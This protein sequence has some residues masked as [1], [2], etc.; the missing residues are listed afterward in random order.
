SADGRRMMFS[1]PLT[2]APSAE[3]WA[4]LG[5]QMRKLDPDRFKLEFRR[6]SPEDF[7]TFQPSDA[8][9]VRVF[10]LQTA[11]ALPVIGLLCW[12]FRRRL[13][14][15]RDFGARQA[16]KW[17]LSA[18]AGIYVVNITLTLLA[19]PDAVSMDR[20]LDTYRPLY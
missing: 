2:T 7:P 18:L 19:P 13:D 9:T 15:R 4:V 3:A 8:E 11:M 12:V 20:Y 14:A 17:C 16:V 6:L 10:V 1:Y 5:T